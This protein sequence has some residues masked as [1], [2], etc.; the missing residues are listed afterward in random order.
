MLTAKQLVRMI[1]AT[2]ACHIISC[3]AAI[4]AWD[5]TPWAWLVA[6]AFLV[7]GIVVAI[8]IGERG[9]RDD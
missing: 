8:D 3:F 9:L 1:Q 6:F 5:V 2:A 7:I 4:Y